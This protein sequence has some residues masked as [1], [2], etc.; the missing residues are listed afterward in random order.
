MFAIRFVLHSFFFYAYVL[1]CS[2]WNDFISVYSLC[3][4]VFSRPF[5]EI[6]LFGVVYV[7]TVLCVLLKSFPRG[8]LPLHWQG[9]TFPHLSWP[10]L[11]GGFKLVF[12][13]DLAHILAYSM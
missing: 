1:T 8:F 7:F 5:F 9:T 10:L 4:S 13:S 6:S 3:V 12:V 2:D 11:K